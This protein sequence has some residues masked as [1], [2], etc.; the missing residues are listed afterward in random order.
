MQ[1]IPVKIKRL[2]P[3]AKIPEHKTEYAA[4]FDIY[5]HQDVML[6]PGETMKIPTGIAIEIPEG[7]YLRIEDRSGMA[8][9]GIHKAA[10]I[11]D[12]DYRGELIIVLHNSTNEIYRIE[13]HDRIAQ[14][15]LTPA[16]QGHFTESEDLSETSRGAGGFNSTGK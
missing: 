6:Y 8:A 1:K 14:G 11:I 4:G 10:G 2:H 3:D 9:K 15:I 16:M 7:F 12:S 13:K 5:S